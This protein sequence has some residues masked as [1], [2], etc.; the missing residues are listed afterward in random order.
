MDIIRFLS[1]MLFKKEIDCGFYHKGV[2]DGN[3]ANVWLGIIQRLRRNLRIDTNK[4]VLFL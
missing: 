4:I 2:V 3:R 1:E